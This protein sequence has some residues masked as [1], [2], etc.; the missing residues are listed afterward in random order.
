MPAR[1]FGLLNYVKSKHGQSTGN[2]GYRKHNKRQLEACNILRLYASKMDIKAFHLGTLVRMR[3]GSAGLLTF[4][5][6][7]ASHDRTGLNNST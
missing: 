3:K 1:E 7:T 2:E 5:Y 4:E 6:L